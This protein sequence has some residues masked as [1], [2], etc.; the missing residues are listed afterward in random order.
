MFVPQH[1]YLPLGTLRA[2][3]CYPRAPATVSDDRLCTV[4]AQVGLS[5]LID[6]RDTEGRWTER[7]SP[8]EQQRLM[9]GR[10]LLNQPAWV[11]LDESTSNL[12]T[13]SENQLY[14]LLRDHIP[15]VT[16][17]SVTHRTTLQERHPVT[18][19]LQVFAP[20]Q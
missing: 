10:V 18:I 15:S 2:T 20:S 11:F 6:D 5:A 16:I 1:P 14:D 9:F 19:D 12:D 13:A 8:G 4:L 17:V 3:L 7:L